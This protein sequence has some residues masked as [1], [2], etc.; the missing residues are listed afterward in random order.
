MIACSLTGRSYACRAFVVAGALTL[1][2]AQGQALAGALLWNW[3]VRDLAQVLSVDRP[4]DIR[5]NIL[6]TQQRALLADDCLPES[7]HRRFVLQRL[8]IVIGL[9]MAAAAEPGGLESLSAEHRQNAYPVSILNRDDLRA[10]VPDSGLLNHCQLN[11]YELPDGGFMGPWPRLSIILHWTC[12]GGMTDQPNFQSREWQISVDGHQVYQRGHI[13]NL[14]ANGGFENT[15]DWDEHVPANWPSQEYVP[16]RLQ[17]RALVLT[18]RAGVTTTAAYLDNTW[19]GASSYLSEPWPVQR[20]Q[21][22][23][24]SAWMK[25]TGK[26]KVCLAVRWGDQQRWL[27]DTYGGCVQSDA[28]QHM[29][30]LVVVGSEAPRFMQVWLLARDGPGTGYFDDVMLVSLDG[31]IA[32]AAR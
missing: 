24:L 4:A 27:F 25:S 16:N 13:V 9:R 6:L 28:W 5:T 15:Y 10:V 14:L 32:N 18:Q 2:V 1:L 22:Y 26:T 12:P 19:R 23:L 3:V 31:A 20:G 17:D 30:Y 7:Q 8:M 11:S 21:V 29:A